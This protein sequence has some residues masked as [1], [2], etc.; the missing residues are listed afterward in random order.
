MSTKRRRKAQALS[1]A[2]LAACL[3]FA[4]CRQE[5]AEQPRA[6]PL[7][8]S[9]FFKDRRSARPKIPGTVARG[10][11]RTDKH[12][13]TGRVNGQPAETFPFPVTRAVLERGQ[14]RFN[15][16]CS[17]C[18]GRLGT[19]DGMVVR[20]GFR[21]PTSFHTERLREAPPGHFFDVITNGF[22]AMP[23]YAAQIPAGDRWAIIAYVRG[24]QLSQ[25]A[26]LAEAPPEEQLRLQET[27]P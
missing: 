16:F 4:G 11:L 17:P 1:G 19:G 20:R 13:T 6:D 3:L 15:I 5:M 14:D 2:C 23:D 21:R 10:Q 18:H 22:G 12:L 7:E 9:E 26:S 24:L 25:H 27:E 8:A